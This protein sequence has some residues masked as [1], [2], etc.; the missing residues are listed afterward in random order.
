MTFDWCEKSVPEIVAWVGLAA[1][2][3]MGCEISL[4]LLHDDPEHRT[5]GALGVS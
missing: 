1:I 3:T 5:I 4:D 2:I